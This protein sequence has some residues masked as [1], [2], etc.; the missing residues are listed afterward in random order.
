MSAL[1]DLQAEDAA[2]Q[3]TVSQ[4]LSDFASAL[5]NAQGDPAA[6]EQ[7]VSDM[8]AMADQLTAADPDTPAPAAPADAGDPPPARDA[9]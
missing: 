4:V 7:V 9:G 6:I 2:L 8:T 1:T 5:L 3:A